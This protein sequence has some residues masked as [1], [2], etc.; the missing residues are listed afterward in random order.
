MA[1]MV[2]DPA[3]ARVM[4]TPGPDICDPFRTVLARFA[5]RGIV[6]CYWRSLLRVERALRGDGDLD[7]LVAQE[8]RQGAETI[9]T[10]AGFKRFPSIAVRTHPGIETYL[11]HDEAT[12]RL[13]HVHLHMR[14][15]FG[16]AL[17]KQFHPPWENTVL[18]R[19]VTHAGSGLPVLDSETE[20]VL[21]VVRWAC[22]TSWADPVYRRNRAT[23]QAKFE[24]DRQALAL[25]VDPALL[26]QRAE[27]LLG[28]GCGVPVAEF[29]T[30]KPQR[31]TD[32]LALRRVHRALAPWRSGSQAEIAIRRFW[33]VGV[34]AF[35]RFNRRVLL[36]PRP[37]AHICPGGGVVIAVMG[38]DGSGKS[39]LVRALHAWLGSEIDV[40]PI[41]FGTG[42]GRP[43]LLL[44][45]FKALVPLATRVLR[46]KPRG[47]SHGTVSDAPPS[48]AYAILLAI[49]A[50]V[51]SFEKRAKLRAARRAA[52]RGMVVVGDRFPQDQIDSYNDG[53]LLPRLAHVPGF[54]RRFEAASYA[55]SRSLPP[56]L[57]IKLVAP[58]A[59]LAAR[60]PSMDRGVI[61]DRIDSLLDLSFPRSRVAIL[62]ADSPLEEVLAAARRAVWDLL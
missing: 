60:E 11:A 41:Y 40:L 23:Q 47:A 37:W 7:L 55:L 56:D 39:T 51:L 4:Q 50:T 8:S 52:D 18:S 44:R 57:V 58:V 19:R 36:Q 33:R 14:L 26:W 5:E 30:G 54:L 25:R 29:I 38:V 59:T 53:P 34:A 9:L 28:A 3:P 27:D 62:A 22:E 32:A 13:V 1:V 42:D 46:R 10:E 21:L 35:G 2:A 49:W 24:R 45:P 6:F 17:L 15:V 20:A 31:S 16:D 61:G 12:G 48:G 43:S